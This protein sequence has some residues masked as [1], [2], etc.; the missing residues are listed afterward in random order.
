M[1]NSLNRL[2][3]GIACTALIAGLS[4]PA[5]AAEAQPEPYAI[6]AAQWSREDFS[7]DAN[8]D[9]FTATYDRALYNA[10]RQTL[11]DGTSDTAP[12]YTM[13]GDSEYSAVKNLLARMEGVT[14][15]EHHVPEN[16]TNYYQYLDYFAVSAAMPENYQAPFDFIQPIIT[17]MS[18]LDT[19][20][21]KV[22]YLNDYLCTLLAYKKGKT[23]GVTRTFTQHSGELQAACGSYA[24]A[25]KFLCGAAGI[26]CFT[27]STSNHTWNMVYVDGQWLHVDVSANDL[28]HRPYILLAE[29]VQGRTDR[30]PEQTAF[31]KELLVPGSTK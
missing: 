4:V 9:V 13:V 21:E 15:Y 17:E 2:L 27:I 26:P 7:Q 16:F 31:L 10:I 29:T 23:A 14:R 8:P 3:A 6:S 22:E 30:A 28:Y 25:F 20:S 1:K 18:E 11:V 24:R 19:D 12:A 5:H